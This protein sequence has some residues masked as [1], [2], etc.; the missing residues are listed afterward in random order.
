MN[1]IAL[2]VR[3]SRAVVMITALVAAAGLL[4]GR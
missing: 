4:T 3:Q 2:A 1:L